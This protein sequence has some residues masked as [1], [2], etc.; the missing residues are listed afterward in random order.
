MSKQTT[1]GKLCHLFLEI[2]LLSF[3][4]GNPSTQGG[5]RSTELIRNIHTVKRDKRIPKNKFYK[6]KSCDDLHSGPL[7]IQRS[8]SNHPFF[9]DPIEVLRQERLRRERIRQEKLQREKE[10]LKG[11]IYQNK[12]T[13]DN[14]TL[15]NAEIR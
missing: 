11:F 5:L 14:N 12:D 4:E 13:K 6:L 15:D 7:K 3:L 10:K 8:E 2:Y 9:N 1:Q